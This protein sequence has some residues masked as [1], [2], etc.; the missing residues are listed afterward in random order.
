MSGASR[1]AGPGGQAVG[2][3]P[4]THVAVDP[5]SG[6]ES[7]PHP[8]PAPLTQTHAPPPRG[9]VQATP[10]GGTS[11]SLS[12][13]LSPHPYGRVQDMHR[14]DSWPSWLPLAP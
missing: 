12:G 9:L 7:N 13:S 5:P 14:S 3:L 4:F 10:T 6:W 2:G 8:R 1:A 11:P